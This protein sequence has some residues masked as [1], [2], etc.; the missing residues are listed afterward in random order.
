ML[1]QNKKRIC[2]IDFTFFTQKFTELLRKLNEDKVELNKKDMKIYNKIKQFTLLGMLVTQG[3]F[4]QMNTWVTP[5]IQYN[6]T[7]I[8]TPTS[9]LYSGAP[10]S[11]S[12][13]VANGAHD[14]DG[15]LLFYVQGTNVMNPNGTAAGEL[16]GYF[17]GV[18]PYT[19]N[20]AFIQGEVAIVPIP[21][22]CKQFYVIYIRNNGQ[23]IGQA[24]YTKVDCSSGSVVVTNNGSA[25]YFP[26][27]GGS[28]H[29][30]PGFDIGLGTGTGSSTSGIAVSKIVSGSDATAVRFLYTCGANGIVKYDITASGIGSGTSFGTLSSSAGALTG[31]DYGTLELELSPDGKYLA[32][33]SAGGASP[34]NKVYYCPLVIASGLPSRASTKV[35]FVSLNSIKGLE[36]DKS[37]TPVLYVIGGTT[38]TNVYGK[39]TVSPTAITP[40]Y[41]AL[42]GT[43]YDLSQSFLEFGKSG[44]LY[45]V[46]AGAT[47][48]LASITLGSGAIASGLTKQVYFDSRHDYSP[49]CTGF[50]N[51]YTLPDQVDGQNYGDFGGYSVVSINP[52]SIN[53][54]PLYYNIGTGMFIIPQGDC[55]NGG[56]RDFYTCN[57]L[58]LNS[59]YTGGTPSNYKIDIKSVDGSCVPVTGGTHMNYVG[60]WASGAVP[61]SLDLRTLTDG[62]GNSLYTS[63][64]IHYITV[65][66][67]NACGNITSQSGYFNVI[68]PGVAINL[69]IYNYTSPGTFMSPSHSSASP[70]NVGTATMGFRID[71][72]TGS[73]TNMNILVEKYTGTYTTIFNENLTPAYGSGYQALNNFC[74]PSAVW[75]TMPGLTGN[76]CPPAPATAI[77]EKGYF[78]Y[79][80]GLYSLNNTYRL[81]ITLTDGCANSSSD[82]AFI[83]PVVANQRMANAND[84]KSE[85]NKNSASI[86][87]NPSINEFNINLVIES[88]DVYTI[89]MYDVTGKLVKNIVTN[90]PYT[91]GSQTIQVSTTDLPQGI[92]TYKINSTNLNTS[93]LISISK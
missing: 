3:L 91:K 45:A 5:P 93:G 35:D 78:G 1:Y 14:I 83:K 58:T 40:S 62:S 17:G 75:G 44:R 72:S 8:T 24:F 27:C 56:I 84:A 71:N 64:G 53:S 76:S 6:M 19:A 31:D 21:G 13:E 32:W 46:A 88:D 12:Y 92:Y 50:T 11:G 30:Y 41:T 68:Q 52:L 15:T 38:G 61:S 86:Y 7:S 51:V 9:P 49:W 25:I 82:Y 37:A 29:G 28:C 81:T 66:V 42:T 80:N 16:G 87:P 55:D 57:A 63:S 34:T 54:L 48:K 90:T 33:S 20:S 70:N 2:V 10:S 36:F 73:Y 39:F 65:S 79:S 18:S 26:G 89:N 69:E 47:P 67:K 22:T 4:A 85:I 77:A 43:G 59:S 23:Y 60:S 74:V